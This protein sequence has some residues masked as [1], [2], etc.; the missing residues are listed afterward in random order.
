L[1]A[2]PVERGKYLLIWTSN[3]FQSL[4]DNANQL[5]IIDEGLNSISLSVVTITR[6]YFDKEIIS[7]II[8]H[9]FIHL[10]Q[11]MPSCLKTSSTR[12]LI[13]PMHIRWDVLGWKKLEPP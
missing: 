12:W 9:W 6:K 1:D 7:D 8:G 2:D 4:N 13:I 10:I 5:K 11:A 3:Q